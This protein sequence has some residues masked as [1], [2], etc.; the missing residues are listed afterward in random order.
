MRANRARDS[1]CRINDSS[2][3]SHGLRRPVAGHRPHDRLTVGR[4]GTSSADAH[5]P[6]TVELTAPERA[7][8]AGDSEADRREHLEAEAT[9]ASTHRPGRRA[10]S[11]GLAHPGVED[12]GA[13]GVRPGVRARPATRGRLAWTG[14]AAPCSRAAC[15]RRRARHA[16]RVGGCTDHEQGD[17][18]E[19]RTARRRRRT[20]RRDRTAPPS[21][22]ATASATARVLPN[23]DSHTTTAR[24]TSGWACMIGTSLRPGPASAR[25]SP[26]ARAE[27]HDS[28]DPRAPSGA[29]RGGQDLGPWPWQTS[30][31]TLSSGLCERARE[32]TEG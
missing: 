3:C 12:G 8:R 20:R 24:P 21:A 32:P 27:G 10:G 25:R 31:R 22:S 9:E 26:A 15:P 19:R 5:S 1:R 2:R 16:E 30:G 4:A 7:R 23:I 6:S 11:E 17:A 18:V 14:A 29:G 28:D 13:D